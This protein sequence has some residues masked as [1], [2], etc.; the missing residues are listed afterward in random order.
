M[1]LTLIRHG[2]FKIFGLSNI[3]VNHSG[4]QKPHELEH[5]FVTRD[6]VGL[7]KRNMLLEACARVG[8]SFLHG[9][10]GLV[11]LIDGELHSVGRWRHAVH[12]RVNKLG[13]AVGHA[14]VLLDVLPKLDG[15]WSV[16]CT[17]KPLLNGLDALHLTC[18]WRRRV[19]GWG[20]SD[21]LVCWQ[22]VFG[23]D[24]RHLFGGRL[25][26]GGCGIGFLLSA[27]REGAQ[28]QRKEDH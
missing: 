4:S 20:R 18:P 6:E 8:R 5:D 28:A 3:H 26:V 15:Q 14:S 12:R 21:R 1:L 7:R 23:L 17:L 2:Q 22:N 9:F 27:T 24:L 10:Y 13:E 11:S 16:D 19:S 25:C